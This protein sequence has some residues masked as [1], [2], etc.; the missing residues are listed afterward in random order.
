MIEQ[1]EGLKPEFQGFAFRY[2]EHLGQRH[3]E[4]IDAGSVEKP[5]RDIAQ[6]SQ[7]LGC[8]SC[9]GIVEFRATISW[10]RVDVE[11]CTVIFGRVQQIVVDSVSQRSQQ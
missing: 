1:V 11:R 6:S 7:R 9:R 2:F 5:A 10:V 8:E 4:I 3:V